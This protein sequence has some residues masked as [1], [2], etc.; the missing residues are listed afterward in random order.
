MLLL[1]ACTSS[2]KSGDS[3]ADSGVQVEGCHAAPRSADSHELWLSFPY[4]SSGGQTP[5][6]KR[7]AYDGL[8][9]EEG[10]LELGRSTG[11]RGAWTP[12]G[13]FVFLVGDSGEVHTPAGPWSASYAS[14]VAISRSGE[15]AFL[16]NPNWAESGGGVYRADIDCD[17]G[18]LG[19]PELIWT[20][21]N[22]SVIALRPGTTSEAAVISREL[23]G[24]AGIVH[25]VDLET[26]QVLEHIDAFG[27]DEAIV[28][29]A[30][31]DFEG[32]RLLVADYSEWSGVPTRVAVV[33]DT[34]PVGLIEVNDP[35]SLVT[36]PW[37]DS[38]ALVVS[39]YGDAVYELVRTQ[40]GYELGARVASPA[41]PGAAVVLQRGGQAG[42]VLVVENTGL[43][44]LSFTEGG[45]VS[46]L[47]LL[48]SWSGL[49]GIPGAIAL[50]P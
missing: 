12:D 28:S 8:L 45:G 33:E 43:Q 50:Q 1:L 9:V 44:E 22:A 26:G 41:L 38:S 10:S 46:D 6:W 18:A 30:A 40:D 49:D 37:P 23:D 32:Q 20:G 31:W 17:T 34:G 19:S 15:Q 5:A 47:G 11:G 4:T 2:P 24:V 25:L 3:P 42:R 29:D 14:S 35:V 36:A 39:G 7:F 16:V 13:A 21:K 27:D 48:Q